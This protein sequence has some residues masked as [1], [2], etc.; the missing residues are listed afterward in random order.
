MWR[1]RPKASIEFGAVQIKFEVIFFHFVFHFFFSFFPE[2]QVQLL[3][4]SLPKIAVPRNDRIIEW[5]VYF[6]MKNYYVAV[7]H[8]FDS[9]KSARYEDERKKKIHLSFM[10]TKMVWMNSKCHHAIHFCL[11]QSCS[12]SA[13]YPLCCWWFMENTCNMNVVSTWRQVNIV[14]NHIRAAALIPHKSMPIAVDRSRP[15]LKRE[16]TQHRDSPR[17]SSIAAHPCI[18]SFFGEPNLQKKHKYT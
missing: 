7:N 2:S 5:F 17:F 6:W 4:I 3:C 13:K 14:N 15:I 12:A 16:I 10:F 18:Y 8:M 9:V 11:L 1:S